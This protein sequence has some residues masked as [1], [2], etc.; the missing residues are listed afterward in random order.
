MRS[1]IKKNLKAAKYLICF[2]ILAS[3]ASQVQAWSIRDSVINI[4]SP[5]VF[6]ICELYLIF[7]QVAGGLGVLIFTIAG[8]MWVYSRD[9]PATRKKARATMIAVIIGLLIILITNQVLSAI[10]IIGHVGTCDP[11]GWSWGTYFM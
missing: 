9:D 1:Q 2:L 8:I 6:I 10:D 3:A 11:V 7:F 4:A 5:I